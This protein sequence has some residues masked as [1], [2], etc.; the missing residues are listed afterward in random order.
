MS[1]PLGKAYITFEP[2]DMMQPFIDHLKANPIT[3][4]E[5]EQRRLMRIAENE[6]WEAEQK[7]RDQERHDRI[8]AGNHVWMLHVDYEGFWDGA[9]TTEEACRTLTETPI[10]G[11]GFS[12]RPVEVIE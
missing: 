4:E 9:F 11:D 1:D 3:D 7:V 10:D 2:S 6:K 5:R 8:I 12:V